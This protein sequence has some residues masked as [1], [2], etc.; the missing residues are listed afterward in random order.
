MVGKH[1]KIEWIN[2]RKR[3]K[4]KAKELME[5]IEKD[6]ATLKKLLGFKK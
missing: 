6:V 4:E 2:G 5:H 3:R 1:L